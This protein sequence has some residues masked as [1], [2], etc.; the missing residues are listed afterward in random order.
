[1]S[2]PV[3]AARSPIAA[4]VIPK[5]A[6]VAAQIAAAN[7]DPAPASIAECSMWGYLGHS[8]F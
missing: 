6:A 5:L 3:G 2:E 7:E 4:E 1:M 8:G